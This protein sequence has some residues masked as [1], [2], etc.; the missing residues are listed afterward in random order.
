MIPAARP[1][2]GGSAHRVFALPPGDVPSTR[3]RYV[4]EL[5]AC[6]V[7]LEAKRGGDDPDDRALLAGGMVTTAR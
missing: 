7:A 5:R 1:N 3:A 6:T 2:L 4:R